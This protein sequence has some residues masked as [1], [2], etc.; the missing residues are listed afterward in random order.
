MAPKCWRRRL[1]DFRSP[2]A[3]TEPA[4][5]GWYPWALTP[6]VATRSPIAHAHGR[7]RDVACFQSGRS[8]SDSSAGS[9]V[10][11]TSDPRKPTPIAAVSNQGVRAGTGVPFIPT[12]DADYRSDF[13]VRTEGGMTCG[14]TF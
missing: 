12:A 5:D 13:S 7:T 10:N 8:A 4:L 6:V 1:V 9:D 14:V 2:P 11:R 3:S